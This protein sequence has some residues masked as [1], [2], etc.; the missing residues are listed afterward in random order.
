MNRDLELLTDRLEDLE[1]NIV[2][3]QSQVSQYQKTNKKYKTPSSLVFFLGVPLISLALVLL[4]LDVQYQ[5]NSKQIRYNNDSLVELG[6][7]TITVVSGFYSL[8]KYR[9]GTRNK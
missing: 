6:L 1:D 8:K 5:S 4:G 9:D 7:S 2:N 3:L